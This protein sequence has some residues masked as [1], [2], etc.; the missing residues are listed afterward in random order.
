MK[1]I[2]NKVKAWIKGDESNGRIKWSLYGRVWREVGRAYWKW[3][4]AGVVF[5]V[6][7]AGAEAYTITLVQQVVDRAFIEKSINAVYWLGIQVVLAFGAKGVF[8]YAKALIMSKG[9]L[10]ASAVLQ[11][12]IYKHM[13][14]MNLAR[15]YKD[16]MGKNLNYFSIQSAAVL[17]LVTSTVIKIVQNV[18]TLLMTLGLMFYYAHQMCFV[19]MFLVPAIIIPMVAI[20]RRRRKLAR[21][22]FG[23]ANNV[24]QQLNQ[25]L[26]GIKTIQAFAAEEREEKNFA[27]VLNSS[28][29]NAYKN[30]QANA[31]R[32]PLMEF[33]ISIGLCIAMIMGGHFIAS[34][35]ITTGDFTAFLL[36]LTAAYKPAK[37]IT[38]TGDTLQHGLL[39]AETLFEF[40]DSK[41]D[42]TDAPDARE[43]NAK[44]M[45]VGFHDVSFAYNPNEP[46]LKN[47]NLNVPAGK[48]CALVGPS[49]GGKTTMFNLL[50]RFYDPQL[51]KITIN[52]TDIKKYT[53]KSL[54]QNIAEVSQSVFLFKGT[55]EDNI[56]YGRPNATRE[57]VIAA[58]Q[59]AN[60]HDFIMEFPKGYE[61][62]VG[63]AGGLLSGG[64]KQRVAIARAI[65]KN[66]PI[67]LLDEATSALDTQSEKLIQAALN[68]LMQGRTTFVIAHRL[69]TILD[70]DIIC[71]IKNGEIVEMGTDAE[72][73]ALGG[74][75]KKLRDIQF[76]S[77]IKVKKDKE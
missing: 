2:T 11:N 73:C 66:A 68:D 47:I 74:E 55:I 77:D 33:M 16:G 22:S 3:L 72:L 18:S 76:K 27:R 34:G 42:I 75:Y 31:L 58:A 13:T 15:F 1:K 44:T 62:N 19:L 12:R 67:L 71:V 23:I 70:A 4:L 20:M 52:N 36:A 24:T 37:S 61:T 8:T 25:T 7:A 29:V 69:S 51:G 63:E 65:L 54:R 6:L 56:K 53:L 43:L 41:P 50:E 46:V 5:T 28:M 30:T 45:S 21:L 32:S 26:Q 39:A 49:G 40:L 59:A 60:A 9:G 10:V 64:Q 35:A 38:G 17:N 48:V 57:E 14:H